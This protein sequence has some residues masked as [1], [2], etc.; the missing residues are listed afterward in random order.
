M[1]RFIRLVLLSVAAPALAD[2]QPQSFNELNSRGQLLC[3]SALLYFDPVE[4]APD[5]RSL[6]AVYHHLHS[7]QTHVL[8][9]GQPPA[10]AE[11]L[12]A[13]QRSFAT[14]DALP[15]RQRQAYPALLAQLLV[16]Q[17]TL[18]QA[19]ADAHARAAV[20]AE[21]STQL[22]ERQSLDLASLL[23][24]YQ[25]RHYPWPSGMPVAAPR[26]SHEA[27]DQA[28]VERFEQLRLLLPE[29]AEALA[30]IRSGYQFVRPLLNQPS[31]RGQGGAEFY[32]SR[33]VLDLDELAASLRQGSP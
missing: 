20:D 4:R 30:K 2:G 29:H 13:M 14:L 22:L 15:R 18:Q 5:P 28:L 26:V 23:L 32:L 25:I 8:Q 10:L 33:A 24:D 7:L 6:T 12:E 17:R 27:L 11:P 9:L 31:G 16:Q 21:P 3:A 19:A 1:R